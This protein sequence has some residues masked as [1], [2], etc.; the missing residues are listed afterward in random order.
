MTRATLGAVTAL[1]LLSACAA[2]GAAQDHTAHA[3]LDD[4]L[5]T[6]GRSITTVSPRAQAFFD[7]GLRLEYAFNHERALQSYRDALAADSGCAMCWWGIALAAGPN[8]NGPM[9]D[10]SGRLAW[11]AVG[12]ARRLAAGA[13]PPERDLIEALAARYGPEPQADRAVLD[14]AYARAMAAVAARHGNDPGV[15][16]L[17][18]AALMNLSPWNYWEGT[19]RARTPRPGT[20]AILA[21]LERALELEPDNPGACHYYIHAVEAA[22]PD[23]ALPCAE[24]LAALMPGAGHLVHMPAHIYLR[25]GRYADAVRSNQHAVHADESRLGDQNALGV[26]AG[27]YYPHNYH[28]MA[29]AATM[30]GMGATA[31]EAA[32]TVAPRVPLPVAREVYWIQNAVVLP[33]LTLVAFGRWQEVLAEPLPPEELK[34]ASILARYA[35]GVAHAALGSLDSARAVLVELERRAPGSA[36]DPAVN[37]IWRITPLVLAGEIALRGGDAASAVDRFRAA[38]RLEDALLYEEPPLW[39][40]P[41]RHSLGRALLEAGRPAEAEQAYREDLDRFPE[42]GWSLFGLATSLER[43]GKAA[44]AK[45]VWRRFRSAW[46]GADVQ[47]T[48]SRF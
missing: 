26:Y 14:S 13:S 21:T 32:R 25:V 24:R 12:E 37:P 48:A 3:H 43:Q 46:S 11:R 22:Y 35:R 6:H 20:E 47:L 44:E 19:Y 8:I 41:V 31:L 29:F 9:T 4:S 16:T 39:Y 42:N 17:Y 23:R 27:A 15:L 30:A 18:A 34:E 40:Y 33:A 45:D 2:G 1:L 7:Q 10:E 5:G 36:G 38:A 28:F